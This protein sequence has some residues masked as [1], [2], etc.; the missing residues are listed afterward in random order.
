M[1]V[2]VLPFVL[3]LALS[4]LAGIVRVRAWYRAVVHACPGRRIRYR[5]VVVAHLGGA[6]LNG[7]VVAHAGDAVKLGLVKRRAPDTP[8]GLLVGT[9]AP[10][11]L[12]EAAL[13]ALL[14][15][16]S[17]SAGLLAPPPLGRLPLPVIAAVAAAA[18]VLLVVLARRA[19]GVVRDLRRGMAGVRDARL[20][21]T[22]VAPW[23]VVARMVRLGA[24]LCFMAAVGL[25]ATLAGALLVMA[26]QGGIGAGGAASTP[27]RA[28]VLA[29]SL[30]IVA[31]QAVSMETV[32]ALVGTQFAVSLVN[33]TIS[34]VVVALILGTASPRRVAD[35]FREAVARIRAIP[36]PAPS[37]AG[38]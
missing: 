12:V 13:T 36:R 38:S 6:G 14:I 20:L 25:P 29:A 2:T 3:G 35:H 27:V 10:P 32:V 21:L 37:D 19:P 15:A 28:A 34:F 33:L 5:D 17:V 1:D 4:V 22:G 7:L 16:W 31:G 9:F 30:P 11:A 8:F 18:A 24:I 26:I 23:L